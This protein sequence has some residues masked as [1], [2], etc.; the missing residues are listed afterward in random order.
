MSEYYKSLISDEDVVKELLKDS[1]RRERKLQNQSS[2]LRPNI[3]FFQRTVKH[4]VANNNRITKRVDTFKEDYLKDG[5]VRKLKRRVYKSAIGKPS[6]TNYEYKR[7]LILRANISFV[8]AKDSGDEATLQQT[9]PQLDNP[10]SRL[11]GEHSCQIVEISGSSDKNGSESD[12]SIESERDI[13]RKNSQNKY[14]KSEHSQKNTD[15]VWISSDDCSS[16][17]D[18]VFVKQISGSTNKVKKLRNRHKLKL[19][20][21]IYID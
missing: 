11:N 3:N 9:S 7:H 4:L 15:M 8:K 19:P 20:P 13:N 16:D 1:K 14:S 12:S 5:K 2:R 10:S 17:S 21:Y 18:V 6:A